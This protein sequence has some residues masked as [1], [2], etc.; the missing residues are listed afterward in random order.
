MNLN[1]M[2]QYAEAAYGE[3]PPAGR[4]LEGRILVP[5]PIESA[6]S[7]VMKHADRLWY[8][9]TVTLPKKW[10]N[11]NIVLHFGAVDWEAAI[12]VNGKLAGYHFGGYDPFSFDITNAL[13]ADGMQEIVVGVYDPTDQGEQPRGKQVL[14][15]RGIWYT[16]VTGIWQT[17][18]LEPVAADHVTG[19]LAI[20]DVD[21]RKLRLKVN[22]TGD[23]SAQSVRVVVLDGGKAIV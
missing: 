1:G 7:G 11:R 21:G 23:A 18:W 17:V 4:E 6:L 9:T 19:T 12:Y 13:K 22:A 5:Y 20:P 16:P 14:I 8:R 3:A 10:K 15:P 2:W